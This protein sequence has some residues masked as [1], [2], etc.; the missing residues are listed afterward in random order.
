MTED[1]EYIGKEILEYCYSTVLSLNDYYHDFTIK[2]LKEDDR[3]KKMRENEIFFNIFQLKH[4]NNIE[5]RSSPKSFSFRLT[6][7]GII[8]LERF[9]L[10]DKQLFINITVEILDFLKR[11]EDGIIELDSGEGQK[12]SSFPISKFLEIIG[13]QE[14]EQ[15]KLQFIVNEIS[16]SHKDERYVYQNSFGY[17]KNKLRFFYN[18]FLTKKG[19]KFLN[20]YKK[21]KN[22][23]KTITDSYAREIVLEEYNDIEYLRKKKNWKDAI[24]KMATILEYLITHYYIENNLDEEKV[25]LLIRG[26]KVSINKLS[27]TSYEN[28]VSYIIQNEVFG[29]QYN[30]DWKVVERLVKDLRDC[31]HLQKYISIRARINEEMFNMIYPAFER[32]IM[33][34]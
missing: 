23:F 33:L 3:F 5:I 6:L 13:I 4:A 9:Y 1:F 25:E 11:V 29:S 27:E 8:F 21:L 19:R 34:F 30:N 7:E 24:I 22:L 32:L 18:L 12:E 17:A 20:Y 26:R 14:E 16:L 2:E 10:R 28:K 15:N 31:I